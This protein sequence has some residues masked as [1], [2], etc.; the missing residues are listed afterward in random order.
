MK[1]T[2]ETIP[3][4]Q[5]RY[6]TAGDWY[7]D[8]K[9]DLHIRVSM[10]GDWRMESL[11]AIHELVEVLLCKHRGITQ[12]QVD[13]FDIEFEKNR[14]DEDNREPGDEPNAPYQ[15]EHCLATSVERLLCA[16]FD[17]KWDDYAA[18]IENLT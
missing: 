10:L 14:G 17:L 12:E 1:I 13:R 2:I 7:Y 16:E 5:Q 6:P 9:G 4:D 15:R 11:V 18:A 3:N 8:E